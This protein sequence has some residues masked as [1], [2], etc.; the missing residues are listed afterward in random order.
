MR[1]IIRS[2]KYKEVFPNIKLSQ[3][4]QNIN[5]WSLETSTQDAY[6]GG[7]VGTNIIGSGANLAITDDLYSGYKDATSETYLQS[8]ELWKQGSH[9]SRKEKNCPEIDIG[10]RWSI[11]DIIGKGIE[12][13]KYNKIIIVPAL[14]ENEA[15]QLMS[16]CEDVKTTAEYLKIREDILPELWNAEYMQEPVE[17]AGLLFSKNKL[18]FFSLS[19]YSRNGSEAT[20]GYIDV[21]DEGT[22]SLSF[23]IA[24]IFHNK[25]FIKDV[26]FTS[27]NIDTTVPLCAGLIQAQDEYDKDKK[28][29]KTTDYIRVEANNQG[30][31]FIRELR[32]YVPA[33][34]VLPVK[35]T[36][37]K[38]SRILNAYGFITKYFY[39]REDY[40]PNSM[41]A[42]FMKEFFAYMKDGSSK[43]D[44]APDS[45]AGLAKFIQSMY[46]HLF[47][48]NETM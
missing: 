26:I 27:E 19:E 43:R 33:E 24:D 32:R 12:E 2:E 18:H 41:Y 39:F 14:K 46:P 1:D 48:N 23:P 44:D 31:G 28:L 47:N 36:T 17:L 22:D 3:D 8:L 4:K 21:M 40:E 9:D 29:I 42:K 11:N 13:K 25:V 35:N 38:H 7:G 37:N 10:T 20:L 30:G 34:K 16:F 45:L 6:F 5:C 15:G